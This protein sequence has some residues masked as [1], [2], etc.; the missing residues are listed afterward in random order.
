MSSESEDISS[1]NDELSEDNFS[2]YSD[3]DSSETDDNPR[4]RQR[5]RRFQALLALDPNL[6]GSAL[7]NRLTPISLS[8]LMSEHMEHMS[9]DLNFIELQLMR[10]IVPNRA[11]G[12]HSAYVYANRNRNRNQANQVHYSRL[13]LFRVVN[14]REANKLCYVMEAR[15][16]NTCLWERNVELRDNGTI[17]IGTIVRVLAP[18]PIK[19]LM[20]G[21]LPM[22][23]TP[24]PVVVMLYPSRGLPPVVINPEIQGNNHLAFSLEAC[25]LRIN[26]TSPE[27]T[28]CGG[29]FC[30]KQRISDWN[31]QMGC[32]C[33]SMN[34]RRSNLALV[35][36]IHIQYGNAPAESIAMSNFSS[37]SFSKLYLT[38]PISPS[39]KVRHLRMTDAYF[40]LLDDIQEVVT[41][42]NTKGGFTVSGW[43]KRGLIN[44]KTLV[45]GAT[46]TNNNNV[47][48]ENAQVESG[49][50][51][52]HIVSI[53]PTNRAFLN[54]RTDLAQDLR[55][56][57]FNTS[58]F[59]NGV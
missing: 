48:N 23:E 49:E 37:W 51:N 30:D 26:R 59:E 44:D 21:D 6:D 38:N 18:L 52:Y 17:T 56:R 24:Y 8:T 29:L 46:P 53:Q 4:D 41:Y 57:K 10:I 5:Q 16:A 15:N 42:I 13:F 22:L 19:K 3:N 43:Y 12:T 45:E 27:E 20:S 33:Y 36:S 39:T 40:Q 11:N 31:G 28:T 47:N 9:L 58:I 50:I 25:H 34:H 35:H 55:A 1:H 32:G 7:M 2:H 54:T 14:E